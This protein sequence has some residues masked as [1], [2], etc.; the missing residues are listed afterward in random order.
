MSNIDKKELNITGM[1][2]QSCALNIERSLKEQSFIQDANVNFSEKKAY[3]TISD[4][5]DINKVIQAVNDL[6]YT[7]ELNSENN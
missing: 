2:C 6:G 5:N 7:A 1:S 4:D 3:V